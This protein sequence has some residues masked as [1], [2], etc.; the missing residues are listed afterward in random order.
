M[1]RH[2]PL[3]HYIIS[4]GTL[5]VHSSPLSQSPSAAGRADDLR[6]RDVSLTKAWKDSAAP[7]MLLQLSLP[8]DAV[9]LFGG[10]RE[11]IL[12][13][14]ISG[15]TQHKRR[16]IDPADCLRFRSRGQAPTRLS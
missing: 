9:A 13:V 1:S 16:S 6:N 11:I 2:S 10:M 5:T 4:M 14:T 7:T 15:N 3:Y 8:A 12:N